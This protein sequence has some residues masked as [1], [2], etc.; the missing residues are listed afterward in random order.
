[1]TMTS[2]GAQTGLICG[3]TDERRHYDGLAVAPHHLHANSVV[4]AALIFPHP[5]EILGI[6]KFECGSRSA[7]YREWRLYRWLYRR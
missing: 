3:G 1:M 2:P 7:A 4:V 5:L 6:E